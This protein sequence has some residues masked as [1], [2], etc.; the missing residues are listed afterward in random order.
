MQNNTQKNQIE[1]YYPTKPPIISNINIVE[2]DGW[3]SCELEESYGS[4]P[5]HNNLSVVLSGTESGTGSISGY[6]SPTTYYVVDNYTQDGLVYFQLST[7]AQGSG[8]TTTLGTVTGVNFQFVS[9]GVPNMMLSYRHD[10]DCFNAPR[11]VQAAT[12][13]TESPLWSSSEWY[14]NLTGTNITGTGTGAHFNIQ[15]YCVS[16]LLHK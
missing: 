3:F 12:F 2:T 5:M 10:L 1:I 15:R 7:T 4:G 11:E 14:Y 8:V 6:T 13:A 9:N 16:H